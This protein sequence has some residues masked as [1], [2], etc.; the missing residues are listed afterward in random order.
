[1]SP[2]AE[3]AKIVQNLFSA[4]I[5]QNPIVRIHNALKNARLNV[6]PWIV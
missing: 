2:I 6:H 1:M 3:V 4:M 5:V